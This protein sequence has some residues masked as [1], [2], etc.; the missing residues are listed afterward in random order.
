VVASNIANTGSFS[1]TV[2]NSTTSSARIRVREADFAA[3]SGASSTNFTITAASTAAGATISG[4]VTD[5]SGMAVGRA[6]VILTDANG[7]VRIALTNPFGY[8]L[9]DEVPVGE[10]YAA[11]VRHKRLRFTS[12]LVN[13]TDNFTGLNFVSE[14]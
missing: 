5:L 7:N 2:P 8:F 12:Q 13:L 4:Q 14:N 9:F 11:S 6:T 1:W 10:S 3:P